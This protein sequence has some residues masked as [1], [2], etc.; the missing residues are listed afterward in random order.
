M[1]PY[2]G[3]LWWSTLPAK[4]SV[5]DTGSLA[6][7]GAFTGISILTRTEILAV[8]IGG[9][10]PTE[11]GLAALQMG[12]CKVTRRWIFRMAPLHYHFKFKGW[13]KVTVAIRFWI[14]K[15]PLILTMAGTLYAE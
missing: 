6:L 15:A 4:A 1:G 5:R 2:F 9:L 14:I 13:K 10:Y 7:G 11:T 12:F 3:F 8:L